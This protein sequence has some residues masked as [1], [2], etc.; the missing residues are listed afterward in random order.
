MWT[1]ES[2]GQNYMRTPR[3]YADNDAGTLT[4]A[5]HPQTPRTKPKGEP[6]NDETPTTNPLNWSASGGS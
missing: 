1:T 2:T 4:L 3:P 6:A 5:N